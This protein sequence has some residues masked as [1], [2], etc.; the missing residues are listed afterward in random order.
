MFHLCKNFNLVS[1]KIESKRN[2]KEK[3]KVKL[4]KRHNFKIYLRKILFTWTY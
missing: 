4:K 2:S 1:E 3:V